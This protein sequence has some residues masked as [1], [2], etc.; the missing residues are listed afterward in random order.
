M[1]NRGKFHLYSISGCEVKKFEMFSWRWSIHEMTDFWAFLGPNSPKCGPTLLKFEPQLFLMESNTLIQEF[2]K[3]SNFYRNRT[4][5]KFALFFR[6]CPT[7]RPFFSMKEA[8]IEKMFL[9]AK[10]R[11]RAIQISQNQGFIWSQFFRKNMITFCPILAV[12]WW[13]KGRGLTLKA[14]NQNLTEPILEPRFPAF[15]ICKGF[16]PTICR[17]WAF[18][19]QRSGFFYFQPLFQVW[20]LVWFPG[21]GSVGT[22]F[23]F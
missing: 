22:K 9:R 15:R 13:K 20:L 17:S 23:K 16:G 21:A 5:P 1:Y 18:W 8:E 2:F 6:F 11:H 4:F 19:S 10:L 3:N 12:F 14:R 7:L